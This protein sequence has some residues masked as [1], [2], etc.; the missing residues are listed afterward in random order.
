MPVAY[1]TEA[2]P[3]ADRCTACRGSGDEWVLTYDAKHGT[4]QYDPIDLCGRCHGSGVERGRPLPLPKP[5][6]WAPR[7]DALEVASWTA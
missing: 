4:Y 3:P 1:P 5:P 2:I 6:S 7:A